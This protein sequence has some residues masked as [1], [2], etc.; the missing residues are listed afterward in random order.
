MNVQPFDKSNT[1]LI[2]EAARLLV[3]CF[4]QAYTD[5]AEA[6]MASILED[7]KLAM[8]AVENGHLVG[9]IG[10]MPQYETTGWELHPLAVVESHRGKG[11]G[12]ALVAALERAAA[13]KGCITMYL[14]TDDELGRTSLSGTD[15]YEDT[16]EKIKNII[17]LRSHPYKFYQKVGYT[18]VGVIPDANGIGKP[19]IWMAKRIM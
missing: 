16:F 11:V 2:S 3:S 1:Q 17:N 15:L 10:A 19:D 6:E 8:L 9:F 7:G 12:T 18:I 4:P 14:G 5:C 13:Q